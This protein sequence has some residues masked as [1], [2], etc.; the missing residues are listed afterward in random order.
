MRVQCRYSSRVQPARGRRR[1]IAICVGLNSGSWRGRCESELQRREL[2]LVGFLLFTLARATDELKIGIVCLIF[3]DAV[4]VDMLPHTTLF[5][6]N[7]GCVVVLNEL[8]ETE[9]PDVVD[10]PG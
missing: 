4:A 9:T 2:W 6:R 1:L 10:I 7:L 5:T 8:V 3:C